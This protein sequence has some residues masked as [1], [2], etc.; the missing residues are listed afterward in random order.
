[1]PISIF[2][3]KWRIEG[4]YSPCK[5]SFFKLYCWKF[6]LLLRFQFI[7]REF[8]HQTIVHGFF[9]L[10]LAYRFF[11]QY[12]RRVYLKNI[13]WFNWL[14]S[15]KLVQ[16]RTSKQQLDQKR[17]DNVESASVKCTVQKYNLQNNQLVKA[18]IRLAVVN[19]KLSS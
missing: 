4:N 8:L 14:Y 3:T 7:F 5:E 1:M 16:E 19:M 13:I 6:L 2:E 11:P 9:N 12:P 17:K 10:Q 18:E 15:R